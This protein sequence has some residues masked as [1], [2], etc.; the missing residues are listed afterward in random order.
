[1]GNVLQVV[2]IALMK[3]ILMIMLGVTLVLMVI[4]YR[5]PDVNFVPRF[6]LHVILK[7]IA[8]FA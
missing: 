3:K 5:A 2:K 1:M 7:L 8:L 4:I 6:V